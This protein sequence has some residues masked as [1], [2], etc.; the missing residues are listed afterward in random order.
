M[1][2]KSPVRKAALLA[3]AGVSDEVCLRDSHRICRRLLQSDIYQ[4][5]DTLLMYAAI[6]N[7][8]C[9]DE[10]AEQAWRDG[11]PVYFPRVLGSGE[12]GFYRVQSF[13][14]LIPGSFSVMEP[15]AECPVLDTAAM[16]NRKLFMLL[17]GAAFSVRTGA[18]I[19][20]GQGYYDR[21]LAG[22][23]TVR[24]EKVGIAYDFQLQFDWEPDETDIPVNRIVTETREVVIDDKVG[25]I[26]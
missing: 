17:P 18:R 4:R 7:E 14:D 16:E 23:G 12:M 21:F 6:R 10:L 2:R 26:M 19:G 15:K 24:I 1:D 8:V 9:L 3:R 11:K 25:G 22:H 13:E 5:A 20:Y